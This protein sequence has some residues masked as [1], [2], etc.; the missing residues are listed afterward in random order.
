M[1]Y[2]H[3]HEREHE[4]RMGEIVIEID[5]EEGFTK[6]FGEIKIRD[7][8]NLLRRKVDPRRIICGN[9]EKL[10]LPVQRPYWELLRSRIEWFRVGRVR[11]DQNV[12]DLPAIPG[13]RIHIDLE[14]RIGR[15][16]DGM[17]DAA[18]RGLLV[19]A[20]RAARSME[21]GAFNYILRDAEEVK[22]SSDTAFYTWLF[23][24]RR[25]IDEGCAD[26]EKRKALRADEKGPAYSFMCRPIQDVE[27]M[28]L[29]KDIVATKKVKIS[30]N[31]QD[32]RTQE[33]LDKQ[34][35]REE[36]DFVPG[37]LS[38]EMGWPEPVGK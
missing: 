31:D 19:R 37:V 17:G 20:T 16:T 29:L 18:N 11:L 21:D 13:E 25:I 24:M 2:E 28:P 36:P 35:K 22:L 27:R 7:D 38:P 1:D 3:E 34:R 30:Y 33:A 4:V 9:A 8:N 15:V 14:K 23:W 32:V 5:N 26:D 12:T 10:F 6:W